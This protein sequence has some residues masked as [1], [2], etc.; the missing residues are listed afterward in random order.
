MRRNSL[1]KPGAGP[2][3]EQVGTPDSTSAR[4]N[5]GHASLSMIG[6]VRSRRKEQG[7]RR[8]RKRVPAL[9][10]RLYVPAFAGT[11]FKLL[12]ATRTLVARINL[13]GEALEPETTSLEADAARR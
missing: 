9:E 12:K 10:C 3:Q 1:H 8:R 5:P 7:R 4:L 13:F 11:V 2:W 6:R